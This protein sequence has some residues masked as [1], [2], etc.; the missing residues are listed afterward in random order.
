MIKTLAKSIREYKKPSIITVI[1]MACEVF[2]DVLIPFITANLINVI[3]AGADLTEVL[4]TGLILVAMA[5]VSLACGGLGGYMGSKASAGLQRTCAGIFSAGCR[6]SPLRISTG[7][8]PP[9]W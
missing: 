1:L 3:K 4:K 2:I 9:L 8:R 6:A 5:I 7:S